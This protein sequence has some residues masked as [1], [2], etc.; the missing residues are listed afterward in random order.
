MQFCFGNKRLES[1][2][3]KYIKHQKSQLQ[4]IDDIRKGESIS[5]KEAVDILAKKSSEL[6]SLEKKRKN[7]AKEKESEEI[8][9]AEHIKTVQRRIDELGGD[10][11]LKKF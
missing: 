9:R 10:M 11:I 3:R 5:G 8:D 4:A 1:G 7:L 6:I 2:F